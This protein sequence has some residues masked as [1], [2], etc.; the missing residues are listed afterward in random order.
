MIV[1]ADSGS[2]KCD[3]LLIDS[4][5]RDIVHET[6]TSG[7]NPLFHNVNHILE[8]LNNS[9]DLLKYAN[10][11]EHVWYFG[12][13]C[14]SDDRKRV[15]QTALQKFFLRGDKVTVDHDL[16]GAAYATCEGKPGIA[17]ILGTGSNMGVFDGKEVISESNAL[18]FILGDE[19]SGSYMG[20][21]LLRDFLYDRVP[22]QIRQEL[23][24]EFGLNRD[25][26]FDSVYRKPFANV[27]LASFAPFLSRHR[28]DYYVRKLVRKA[29]FDFLDTHVRSADDYEVLPVH[30]VGSVAHFYEDILR[31]LAAQMSIQVG[32]IV[33]Q[34][35][36]HI[37]HYLLSRPDVA[38]AG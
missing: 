27:Y 17:C 34:P 3:W 8:V 5:S 7:F 20:K 25:S 37:A 18:G 21:Q 30:F 35:V 16:V 24:D 11:V 31:E 36:R 23:V 26:V 33:K 29:L 2:T 22:S 12:A 13:S 32:N 6:S 9:D 14:S 15:L 10:E 4:R 28:Q 19:G 38:V 1:I